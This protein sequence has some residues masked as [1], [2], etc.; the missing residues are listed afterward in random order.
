MPRAE[1]APRSTSGGEGR[2]CT[3]QPRGT[4][5]AWV[6]EAGTRSLWVFGLKT[7]NGAVGL[8]RRAR[9]S[10]LVSFSAS[11]RLHRWGVPTCVTALR[12]LSLYVP[13]IVAMRVG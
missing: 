4:G 7:M 3:A 9:L 8:R 11:H 13:G 10:R 6:P 1:T 5:L 12:G 2:V